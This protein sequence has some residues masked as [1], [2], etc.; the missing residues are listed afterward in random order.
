MAPLEAAVSA[1]MA[2]WWRTQGRARWAAAVAVALSMA[3][4]AVGAVVG[5]SLPPAAAAA[6]APA[7]PAATRGN[8][9]LHR[10]ITHP[11]EFA[12][13]RTDTTCF[14]FIEEDPFIIL[15][16]LDNDVAS[17]LNPRTPFPCTAYEERGLSGFAFK[18]YEKLWPS[19]PDLCV[20]AG[21]I[22]ECT[23]SDLVNYLNGART[24]SH[25]GYGHA[26]GVTG[27]L[28]FSPDRR[29]LGISSDSILEDTLLMVRR[30]GSESAVWGFPLD[31]AA[32]SAPFTNDAW[33]VVAQAGACVVALTGALSAWRPTPVLAG[34]G[35]R[36]C[37]RQL[38]RTA[39]QWMFN[40]YVPS[41]G[42]VRGRHGGGPLCGRSRGCGGG[43]LLVSE[44]LV[45]VGDDGRTVTGAGPYQ[46]RWSTG[47]AEQDCFSDSHLRHLFACGALSHRAPFSYV[48]YCS[49]VS[50]Y[51]TL[52]V[53][54]SSL[55][56]ADLLPRRPSSAASRGCFWPL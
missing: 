14:L 48:V 43:M 6:A 34:G 25:P 28:V 33:K 29:R 41:E 27:A 56:R 19:S 44:C 21:D 3:P 26:L 5:A 52:P 13:C 55:R 37:S 36:A 49:A 31:A 47:V 11:T 45:G 42:W 9:C 4:T 2:T 20:Y 30:R 32:L 35:R 18:L 39:L 7:A 1:A 23:F 38:R 53:G 10:L 46:W 8:N 24:A 22:D 16:E 12:R 54:T 50:A 15:G 17:P 40:L 51:A